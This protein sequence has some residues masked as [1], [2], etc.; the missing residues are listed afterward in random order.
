MNEGSRQAEKLTDQ[1]GATPC[2]SHSKPQLVF[3]R[4]RPWLSLGSLLVVGASRAQSLVANTFTMCHDHDHANDDITSLVPADWPRP[5][6]L[7]LWLC[8]SWLAPARCH[9]AIDFACQF[10]PSGTRRRLNLP[11]GVLQLHGDGS[12]FWMISPCRCVGFID[13]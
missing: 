2:S 12:C 3:C 8:C 4:A 5:L 7:L 1:C 9:L 13:C 11:G 6:L 10:L